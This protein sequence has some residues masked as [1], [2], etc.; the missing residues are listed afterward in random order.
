[1]CFLCSFII[2]VFLT[3]SNFNISQSLWK[4][5]YWE[6]FY[7]YFQSLLNKSAK[8]VYVIPMEQILIVSQYIQLIV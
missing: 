2:L 3:P 7:Y 6:S 5:Y 4:E 8:T 1:M